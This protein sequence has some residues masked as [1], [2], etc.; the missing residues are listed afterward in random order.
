[1]I[2]SFTHKGLKLLWTEEDKSKLPPA[3]LNKIVRLL[4]LID[5]LEILPVDLQGLD[6]LRPHILKG[7]FIDLVYYRHGELGNHF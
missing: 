2:V 4:Y 1:M 3:M 5:N 6:N 7:D